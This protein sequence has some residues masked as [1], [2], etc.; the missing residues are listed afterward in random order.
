MK[1]VVFDLDETLGY[2]TQFGIF[3]DSLLHYLGSSISDQ[4]FD[5]LLDLY[6]EF[7]RP[8]ILPILQ[9][10]KK[11][12]ESNCCHKI[13]IYTNNTGP[14]TWAKQIIGYFERKLKFKLIDQI[15]AAFKI[16][17]HCVEIC[18]TSHNKSHKDLIK[19]TK[20]PE[21]SE[22]CF[23]DDSYYPEMAHEN[24][25]YINIKPYYHDLPFNVMIDK[26]IRSSIGKQLLDSNSDSHSI[27]TVLM[28]YIN[29]FHYDCIPK[30]KNEYEIDKVLGKHIIV[31]LHTFFNQSHSKTHKNNKNKYKIKNKS[32]KHINI[33]K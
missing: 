8:N 27:H 33:N 13:L 31:H 21:N 10:L 32:Y 22:I 11:K 23:I 30:N 17:G 15:I 6:P 16:H 19:C 28:K 24:I 18:R 26:F 14:T 29:K 25:Y 12:K 20:I 2:F 1:I 3:Y 4:Q 5:L 9:Y 7:L